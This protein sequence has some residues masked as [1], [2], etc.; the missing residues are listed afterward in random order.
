MMNSLYLTSRR[1]EYKKEKKTKEKGT[2][3]VTKTNSSLSPPKPAWTTPTET[4][5][6]KSANGFM[7]KFTTILPS[8]PHHHLSWL[9]PPP[10]CIF[11]QPWPQEKSPL[12]PHPL[13]FLAL[14]WALNCAEAYWRLEGSD[15]QSY[16]RVLQGQAWSV[17]PRLPTSTTLWM[18][19]VFSPLLSLALGPRF[20]PYM[21]TTTI[22][23]KKER[24]MSFRLSMYR[25]S[26]RRT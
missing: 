13:M 11:T 4:G 25:S 16:F 18:S 10:P 2:I 9:S 22:C 26:R 17:L 6:L 21:V 7:P 14:S 19:L 1:E 3:L 24:T 20:S 8:H 15:P 23:N 12:L 5:F